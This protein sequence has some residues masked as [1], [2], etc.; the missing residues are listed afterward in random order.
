MKNGTIKTCI[1]C[2][3]SKNIELF[4]A[5]SPGRIKNSCKSCEV[6]RVRAWTEHNQAKRNSYKKAYY[7]RN[8]E[9]LKAVSRQ[10]Y[11]KNHELQLE[12]N[13]IARQKVPK[14]KRREYTRQ[15]KKRHPSKVNASTQLYRSK[16]QKY[17]FQTFKLEL[18]LIYKDCPI[19]ME[20][21]H[22]IPL[23]NDLVSGLHVPWNL[24]YLSP[25][26]NKV[27]GSKFDGT[28]SNDSWRQPWPKNL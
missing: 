28:Y 15:Y 14:E 23:R 10:N 2:N 3:I 9:K 26:E 27:K 6:D 18:K 24:Q 11:Y 1:K 22:I 19:N 25:L 7:Q 16:K 20:V 12:K 17:V 21:D 13:K 4:T 8:K 5:H